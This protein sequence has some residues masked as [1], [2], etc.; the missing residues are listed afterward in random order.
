MWNPAIVK[1]E[2]ATMLVLHF[3]LVTAL[4]SGNMH[5]VRTNLFAQGRD[6]HSLSAGTLD[7]RKQKKKDQKK[8]EKKREKRKKQTTQSK[9]VT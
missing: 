9:K 3:N 7:N 2:T 1:A 5:P 8:R 6:P 4:L